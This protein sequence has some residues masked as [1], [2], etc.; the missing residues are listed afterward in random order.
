MTL[1]EKILSI[2][3]KPIRSGLRRAECLNTFEA[4]RPFPSNDDSNFSMLLFLR[5]H[6]S[7]PNNKVVAEEVTGG[8][9]NPFDFLPPPLLLE[10][11]I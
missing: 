4:K 11:K 2:L 5:S 3:I 1:V 9:M 7:I 6:P 8:G 10:L